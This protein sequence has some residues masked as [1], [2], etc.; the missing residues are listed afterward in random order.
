MTEETKFAGFVLPTKED[1]KTPNEVLL[2]VSGPAADTFL[3]DYV[4]QVV[5]HASLL[6][7]SEGRIRGVAFVAVME[8][9][10][11]SLGSTNYADTGEENTHYGALLDAVGE[12][13]VR[14]ESAISNRLI[15][16]LLNGKAESL[17]DPEKVRRIAE[18]LGIE[19]PSKENE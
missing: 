1:T 19:I 4:E 18:S 15:Q 17:A 14:L 11:G 5:R 10:D 12:L 16:A 9:P 6:G 3:R 8:N 13:K 2:P 7:D